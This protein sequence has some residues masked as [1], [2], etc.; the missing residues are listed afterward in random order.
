MIIHIQ[1]EAVEKEV[2]IIITATAAPF[3]DICLRMVME[4]ERRQRH[5]VTVGMVHS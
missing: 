2:I 1:E 4:E 5:E 3:Q